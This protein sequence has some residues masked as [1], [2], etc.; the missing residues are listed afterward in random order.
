MPSIVRSP[1]PEWAVY[2]KL[3]AAAKKRAG[4]NVAKVCH[5]APLG[6]DKLYAMLNL[7]KI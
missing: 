3:V 4:G 2:V 6:R 5:V 7:E 1:F